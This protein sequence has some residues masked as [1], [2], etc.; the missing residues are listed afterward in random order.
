MY[1][2]KIITKICRRKKYEGKKFHPNFRTLF[3]MNIFFNW[4][5]VLTKRK[6]TK[7]SIKVLCI[8][9]TFFSLS[10]VCGCSED[11]ETQKS[12]D[13]VKKAKKTELNRVFAA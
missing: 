12:P 4:F 2:H 8:L 5:M 10:L 9:P 6:T 3:W 7:Q 13:K 1:V 11:I